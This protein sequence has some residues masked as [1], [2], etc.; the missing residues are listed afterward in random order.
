MGQPGCSAYCASKFALEGWSETLRIE[1]RALGIKVVLVEPGAFK[2]DIW[3]RN[4]RIS[5]LLLRGASPNQERG[6]KLKEWAVTTPKSDPGVVARVIADIADNPN[7]RL[8][9]V[10]GRDAVAR[11]A[12]RAVLPWRWYERLVVKTVGLD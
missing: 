6:R 9:Y 7:P 12:L 11:I 1:V 3:D 8:R 2:T 5:E 4:T 10:V